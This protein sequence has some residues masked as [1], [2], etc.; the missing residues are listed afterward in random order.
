M[1]TARQIV[2]QYEEIEIDREAILADTQLSDDDRKGIEHLLAF[3]AVA[4]E[5]FWRQI[6]RYSYDLYQVLQH[7]ETAAQDD[8]SIALPEGFTEYISALHINHGV[9]DEVSKKKF[10]P[11]FSE[12]DFS[13]VLDAAISYAKRTEKT[14]LE[15][16]LQ[17]AKVY[18]FDERPIAD[19]M[20]SPDFE[21]ERPP[22]CNLYP[23]TVTRKDQIGDLQNPFTVVRTNPGGALVEIHFLQEY[24]SIIR[25]ALPHYDAAIESFRKSG[26]KRTVKLLEIKRDLLKGKPEGKPPHKRLEEWEIAWVLANR[27]RP[28]DVDHVAEFIESYLAFDI[29]GL[30]QSDLLVQTEESRR[31]NAML[32]DATKWEREL[33]YIPSRRKGDIPRPTAQFMDTIGRRGYMAHGST[34]LA[35]NLPNDASVQDRFGAVATMFTNM[36]DAKQEAILIPMIATVVPEDVL[37]AYDPELTYAPYRGGKT[38]E[39]GK[40]RLLTEIMFK[41]GTATHEA[42]HFLA[43]KQSK[44]KLKDLFGTDTSMWEEGRAESGRLFFYRKAITEGVENFGWDVDVDEA[45]RFAY[46]TEVADMVR[47]MRFGPKNAYGRS[48]RMRLAYLIEKEAVTVTEDTQL[49]VDPDKMEAAAE[50]LFTAHLRIATDGDT[51]AARVFKDRYSTTEEATTLV[52]RLIDMTDYLPVDIMLRYK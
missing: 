20:F 31:L 18:F 36:L 15:G 11:D 23:P 10:F 44:E 51:E 1:L 28:L 46:Q 6:S 30:W 25:R 7:I 35:N 41:I 22:G 9:H 34:A 12:E 45:V 40:I 26:R 8:S 21:P 24:G 3:D 43:K 4:E 39:S 48:A 19:I 52:E 50:E 47:H 37:R 16:E 49:L 13:R 38:I 14:R 42:T 2:G 5:M 17:G 27:E 29:R 32:A 33:P